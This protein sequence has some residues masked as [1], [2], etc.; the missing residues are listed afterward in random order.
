M[1]PR[2]AV[3][4]T[5]G[6]LAVVTMLV[7]SWVG[8]VVV[9]ADAAQGNVQRLMYVHVPAAWLAFLAF[10]I[11]FVITALA[12]CRAASAT[13]FQIASN[14]SRAMAT[15]P[16]AGSASSTRSGSTPRTTTK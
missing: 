11:V 7:G 2:S 3:E 15:L 5:L 6:V 9:P 14:S 12:R 8:L 16:A 1:G 10:F 4:K 13:P